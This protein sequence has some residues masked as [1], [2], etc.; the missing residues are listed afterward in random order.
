VLRLAQGTALEPARLAQALQREL[1]MEVRLAAEAGRPACGVL[2]VT[3]FDERNYRLRYT[4]ADG[5]PV[6]REIPAAEGEDAYQSLTLLAG[7]LVRNQADALIGELAPPAA[8]PAAPPPAVAA[9]RPE[10]PA[11]PPAAAPPPRRISATESRGDQRTLSFELAL[12]AGS[13]PRADAEQHAFVTPELVSR[14]TTAW[15]GWQMGFSLFEAEHGQTDKLRLR[16]EPAVEAHVHVL[17]DI[18]LYGQL[19]T[20]TV[21]GERPGSGIAARLAG[22]ARYFPA[23]FLSVALE[24]RLYAVVLG[25]WSAGGSSLPPGALPWIGVLAIGVNFGRP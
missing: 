19:G 6:E 13:T 22:G 14:V 25:N 21:L 9:G 11:K 4:P 17:P 16:W 20:S 10:P 1:A 2:E 15:L 7:N 12:L 24:T 23:P 3:R 8:A 18:S 5:A